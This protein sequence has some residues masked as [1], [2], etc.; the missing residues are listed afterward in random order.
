MVQ[1]CSELEE[2]IEYKKLLLE[3]TSYSRTLL[4]VDSSLIPSLVR[5][6]SD[7]SNEEGVA[8]ADLNGTGQMLLVEAK[9]KKNSLCE[10]WRH[11]IQGCRS[12]GR[13]AIPVWKSLLSVRRM[14]LNE[15]EDLDTWLEFASLCGHGG[16][17]KLA[18]RILNISPGFKNRKSPISSLLESGNDVSEMS[19]DRRIQFAKLQQKWASNSNKKAA[20]KGLE[21]L[22]RAIVSSGDSSYL[23]ADV[24]RDCLLKLGRWKLNMLEVGATVDPGTRSEV[25]ELYGQATMVDPM[26]Y[27]AWHEWGLSNYRAVEEARALHKV[28][29]SSERQQ[30][31]ID[32]LSSFII[33]AAKGLLRASAYRYHKCCISVYDL[34]K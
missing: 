3:V 31:T 27:R 7:L 13:A 21:K 9:Q 8:D 23:D 4:G 12:S 29:G 18:E 1:Q 15:R 34:Y 33:N 19:M 14:V 20:V 11:R 6:R 25:L 16:N 5:T 28:S 32:S 10:K 30:H 17:Y 26:S 22:L 24:H 2:I